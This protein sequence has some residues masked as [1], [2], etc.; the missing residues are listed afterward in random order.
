M[1]EAAVDALLIERK[2]GDGIRVRAKRFGHGE[3]G[4]RFRMTGFPAVAVFFEAD[5]E[6]VVLGGRATMETEL[7][8]GAGVGEFG[9]EYSDGFEIGDVAFAEFGISLHFLF[10]EMDGLGENAVAGGVEARAL[11]A[12]GAGGPSAILRV[13][14]VGAE[15]GFRGGSFHFIGM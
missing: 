13:Q 15:T 14:T 10:G 11:L 9:F 3:S 6:H 7:E 8:I 1:D 4:V 12:F 5:G 2:R